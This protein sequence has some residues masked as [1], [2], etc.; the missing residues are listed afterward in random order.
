MEED[1]QKTYLKREEDFVYT[2]RRYKIPQ[3]TAKI[4]GAGDYFILS[5]QGRLQ[6]QN[7]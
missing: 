4:R 7:H 2:G 6:D 3:V 5:G 1:G